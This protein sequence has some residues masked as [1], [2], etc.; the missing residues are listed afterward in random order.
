MHLKYLLILCTALIICPCCS[1]SSW[2]KYEGNPVLGGP[3]MGTCFDI[4]VGRVL[5]NRRGFR[6]IR[7]GIG[8][9]HICIRGG[10]L[11]LNVGPDALGRFPQG[12]VD[13]LK[14][15]AAWYRVNGESVAGCGRSAYRPPFG[16]AYTQRGNDLY[17]HFL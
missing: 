3:E 2:V 10:N 8:G 12:S 6:N 4:F 9:G 7:S 17:L 16:C 1:N 14:G 5:G 11:L 15:L 13:A